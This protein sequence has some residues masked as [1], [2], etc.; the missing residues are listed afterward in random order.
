MFEG[1]ELSKYTL[2][3]TTHTYFLAVGLG[4]QSSN[5]VEDVPADSEDAQEH[6]IEPAT[7]LLSRVLSV[8]LCA[9]LANFLVRYTRRQ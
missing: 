2:L 6:Q 7:S 5:P 3:P 8:L 4:M 9:T 1:Y